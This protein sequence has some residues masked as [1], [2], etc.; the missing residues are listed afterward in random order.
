MEAITNTSFALCFGD[1]KASEQ[2]AAQYRSR[3]FYEM[4]KQ[5]L[6]SALGT[7]VIAFS[8]LWVVVY[9]NQHIH[10]V[11]FFCFLLVI[12]GSLNLLV[13]LRYG[14]KG[15]PE[16]IVSKRLV[17]LVALEKGVGAFFYGIITL[18]LF[19]ALGETGRAILS[20]TV[21][22]VLSMGAWMFSVLPLA[23][24]LWSLSFCSVVAIGMLTIFWPEYGV[25]AA[26]L[27]FYGA[28]L[29]N[30]TL[31]TSRR[32]IA[33][34]MAQTELHHQHELVSLLLKDFEEN[35]SDWL[36]ETD[37]HG[38][39]RHA[40][41]HLAR[42]MACNPT[43]LAGHNFLDLLRSL[44]IPLEYEEKSLLERLSLALEQTTPFSAVLV[45]VWVKGKTYWWSLTGKPVFDAE[46]RLIGWR[47]VCSDVTAAH[48]R[49]IEMTQLARFDQLTG[50]ANRH[51][52][53]QKLL[54]YFPSDS[55]ALPCTLFLLDLDNFKNVNDSLGHAAGDELLR[56][57]AN[58]LNTVA[59]GRGLL[60]RLGGDEFAWL[61]NGHVSREVIAD[62]YDKVRQ[63]LAL[64]WQFKGFSIAVYGSVG[65]SFAPVDA[66]AATDLMRTCDMALY[67]AKAAGRDA[68]R[69]FEAT[70]ETQASQRLGLLGDMRKSLAAG[71]FCLYYQP[72]IDLKKGTI[73]GFEALIRWQHPRR[74]LVS[75]QEF[76]QLAEDSGLIVP[77]GAWVLEQACHDAMEWPANLRVA[78]NV[79]A[80]QV[81]RTDMF[82]ATMTAL[83]HSGLK[84]ERLELELTES[85]LMRDADKVQVLLKTLREKGVRV[86]LDDFGTGYSSLSYLRSFGMDKLKID[87]SFVSILDEPDSDGSAEAIIQAITQL[88]STLNLE[89]TAEGVET[90]EQLNRLLHIGC[91]YGQGY[92][93]SKPLPAAQVI[94]FVKSWDARHKNG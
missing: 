8:S 72:Q 93:F 39:L 35:A 5:L 27:V 86:A 78:V 30:S 3:Q 20:G 45:A 21:A 57:V 61:I 17:L 74:G 83:R 66:D 67:A 13:W 29:A 49:D 75:P 1:P 44:T 77:L 36:W 37:N 84:P 50:L 18:L 68:M 76:I 63:V 24:L 41:M 88:A 43:D 73:S 7:Y 9:K 85:S 16:L 55:E 64:P 87:R 38:K 40:S 90:E 42:A 70:M 91:N 79:S 47:G 89:T 14:R 15:M 23:G 26:L 28:F 34:L 10:V 12:M 51:Q 31:L 6:F 56:E 65:V 81:E 48:L 92:L 58:R 94:G 80:V 71:D 33:A 32:F 25:L 54:E 53:N 52:F 59:Q 2:V 19:D 11:A 46:S 4:A 62:I 69:Y 82:V 60:A 22:A